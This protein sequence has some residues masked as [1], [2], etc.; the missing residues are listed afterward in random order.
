MLTK[1]R[2]QDEYW[3]KSAAGDEEDEWD[4]DDNVEEDDQDDSED[5]G[6]DEDDNW[7]DDDEDEYQH[8]L[9]IKSKKIPNTIHSEHRSIERGDTMAKKAKVA[10]KETQAKPKSKG[11]TK[12]K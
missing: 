6:D 1:P 4:D 8:W 3:Y 10:A 2:M 7:D 5:F 12:K 11:K 9:M